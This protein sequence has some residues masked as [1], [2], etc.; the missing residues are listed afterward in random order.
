[1]SNPS[2]SPIK[3]W[4]LSLDGGG[5][6]GLSSLMI[7]E[8]ILSRANKQPNDAFGLVC[9][10]SAGG[11]SAIMLGRVGLNIQECV[12]EFRELS[13]NIFE[14]PRWYSKPRG[15][16]VPKYKK[17]TMRYE[18]KELLKRYG[19]VMDAMLHGEH[20]STERQDHLV[21][22]YVVCVDARPTG[23]PKQPTNPVAV[24]LGTSQ[25]IPY[26]NGPGVDC[27][28]WEA[29]RATSAAP[30]YFRAQKITIQGEPMRFLDGAMYYNNPIDTV[31]SVIKHLQLGNWEMEIGYLSIGTG[32]HSQEAPVRS[33]WH[34]DM[35]ISM[36]GRIPHTPL[37]DLRR[38]LK[39]T[40]KSMSDLLVDA[41]AENAHT[42]FQRAVPQDR[43]F[44][45]NCNEE[46][47]DG[48][49][50]SKTRL[51]ECQDIHKIVDVT[52]KYLENTETKKHLQRCADMLRGI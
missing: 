17:S 46:L 49:K 12:E 25:S 9:G 35:I 52:K 7:L 30:T 31:E 42:V 39:A 38:Y 51:D 23:R 33:Y 50:L 10:T 34:I 48:Y 3:A 11:I 27:A 26:R 14:R 1:M 8:R 19:E 2:S 40:G 24:C 43:Y 41:R 47:D 13:Q 32:A 18:T 5:I 36:S 20:P 44:R 29:V 21:P 4:V 15:L 16:L 22:A 37:R 28:V 45:F 6:R